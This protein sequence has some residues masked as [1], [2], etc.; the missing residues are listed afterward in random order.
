M[1]YQYFKVE[2]ENKVASVAF[3]RPEKIQCASHAGL[4]RDEGKFF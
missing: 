1:T 4:D 3:N 2:I